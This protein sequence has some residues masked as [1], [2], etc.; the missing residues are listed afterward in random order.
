MP[1]HQLLRVCSLTRLENAAGLTV[2]VATIAA[3]CGPK[4]L[5]V[6]RDLERRVLAGIKATDR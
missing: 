6:G 4:D 3:I 2:A 1:D 5:I